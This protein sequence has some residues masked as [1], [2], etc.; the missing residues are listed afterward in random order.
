MDATVQAF[1]TYVGHLETDEPVAAA[2]ALRTLPDSIFDNREP[3]RRLFSRM[4]IFAEERAVHGEHAGVYEAGVDAFELFIRT[5]GNVGL[6]KAIGAALAH[7]WTDCSNWSLLD[8][9]TGSGLGLIP[10]LEQTPADQ[11]P[12]S[13]DLLEPS[14]AMLEPTLASLRALGGGVA[15]ARRH[16]ATLQQ[17]IRR[18]EPPL[19]AWTVCQST[20][21]LHNLPPP[22]R[23]EALRWL[24]RRCGRLMVAE[25]DVPAAMCRE[26]CADILAPSRVAL[27]LQSFSNGVAEYMDDNGT[28]VIDGFLIPILIGYFSSTPSSTYEQPIDAWVAD[29]EEA[30]FTSVRKLRL[31]PYWSADAYLLV[32][33]GQRSG[34]AQRATAPD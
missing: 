5:G 3:L 4:I 17:F 32:G 6:Y 30:G 23:R 10:A 18:E 8:I 1:I 31:F 25:F 34:T 28:L 13:M 24:S 20:F 19:A 33:E 15:S 9:G 7:S 21:A 11:R 22:D 26:S 27:A 29:L 2:A 14:E 12:D 16:I